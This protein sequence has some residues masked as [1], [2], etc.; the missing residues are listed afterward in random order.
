MKQVYAE[1]ASGVK[2]IVLNGAL[3][4]GVKW[5]LLNVRFAGRKPSK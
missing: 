3:Q 1:H 2:G 4:K 5:K